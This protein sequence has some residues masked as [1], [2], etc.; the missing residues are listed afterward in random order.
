[1]SY[2][3]VAGFLGRTEEEVRQP[4]RKDYTIYSGKWAIGRIY[5]T[6]M[7]TEMTWYWSFLG[8]VSRPSDIR[9]NGHGPTLEAAKGEFAICWQIWLAWAG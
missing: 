5:Q 3:E 4:D 9:T 8:S 6:G 1:M 7:P 2:A